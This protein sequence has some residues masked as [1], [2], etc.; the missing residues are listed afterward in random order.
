MPSVVPKPP[1][2]GRDSLDF[3][4]AWAWFLTL[5]ASVVIE[6]SFISTVIDTPR[7]VLCLLDAAVRYLKCSL[8]RLNLVFDLCN[9]FLVDVREFRLRPLLGPPKTSSQVSVALPQQPLY[10]VLCVLEYTTL[11]RKI[12]VVLGLRCCLSLLCDLF[13][14]DL[15]T[16]DDSWASFADVLRLLHSF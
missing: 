9:L 7:N 10:L 3:V 1:R 15:L 13:K 6:T 11:L 14:I 8:H 16:L 12:R 2:A 5:V 4:S